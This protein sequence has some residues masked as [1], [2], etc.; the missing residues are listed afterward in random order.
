MGWDGMGWAE[1][2]GGV[3]EREVDI[4]LRG[5]PLNLSMHHRHPQINTCK[6]GI[7]ARIRADPDPDRPG[8]RLVTRIPAGPDAVGPDMK[9][10]NRHLQDRELG[11]H[12]GADLAED[13]CAERP[14]HF[15]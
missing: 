4:S 15:P 3:R 5:L 7:S 2:W 14:A 10:V 13:P 8:Y 1:G 6:I 12:P 9:R 11:P